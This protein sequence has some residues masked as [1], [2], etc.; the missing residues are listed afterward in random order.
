[1]VAPMTTKGKPAP[2]RVPVIHGGQKGLILIDQVR[3]V[4]KLRLAKR[5]GTVPADT[6]T[7]ALL[8]LQ[9]VFTE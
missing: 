2:F 5:L 8:T 4:D 9:E 6:L 3:A 7:A 1:M